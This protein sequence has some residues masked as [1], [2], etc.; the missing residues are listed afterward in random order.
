MTTFVGHGHA[1]RRISLTRGFVRWR[2]NVLGLTFAAGLEV[3]CSF[4]DSAAAAA[5]IGWLTRAHSRL[6]T[7]RRF[8]IWKAKVERHTVGHYQI[9]VFAHRLEKSLVAI[10]AKLIRCQEQSVVR[11]F[12]SWVRQASSSPDTLLLNEIVELQK[13]LEAEKATG[14]L[15]RRQIILG[16]A[17]SGPGASPA[18]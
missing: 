5:K 1:H 18:R 15:L 3:L 17:S 14:N 16:E 13:R 4:K 6:S 8:F 9:A 10:T 12:H 7:M 2:I 11:A